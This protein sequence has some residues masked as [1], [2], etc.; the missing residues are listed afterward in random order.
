MEMQLFFE[1]NYFFGFYKY[2]R[3]FFA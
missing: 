3:G 1:K 2:R